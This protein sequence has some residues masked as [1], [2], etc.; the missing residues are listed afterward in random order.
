MKNRI[1]GKTVLITGATAGIGLACAEMFAKWGANLIL[2]GRREERLVEI[3][4]ALTDKYL[5]KVDSYT[6][7]IRSKEETAEFAASVLKSPVDI[8]V[9]NAGL[10][11]GKDAVQD[12]DFED[13]DAMIDT[14]LKGLLYLSQP[15]S[16]AMVK[17]AEG[18]IINI[19]SIAGHEAYAGGVVYCATKFG[20]N[21]I[22]QA[23]KK[24]LHATGVRVSMVSPGLVNTEFS[25]VR[26]KGDTA[27]ADA[28]YKNMDPLVA[29]DIAEIVIF[30]AN[31]PGHVNI[32]DAVVLPTD[33]SAATMV[34]RRD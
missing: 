15:I 31:R 20:V 23:M 18:H 16:Q 34:H 33:Q 1:E 17:R 6:F 2:T 29:E 7:D 22:T 25:T 10:A 13:W 30:I 28:V 5:V 11:V 19:G 27:A 4:K 26:F 14:N 3:A 32:M 24:D 9:N 8:L 12:G 21:A